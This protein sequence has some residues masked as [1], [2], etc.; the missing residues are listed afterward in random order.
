MNSNKL[1]VSLAL[2]NT[3]ACLETLHTLAPLISLAEIRLDAM[4]SFDLPRLIASAPCP[5]ILTCR[6]PREGGAFSGPESERLALLTRAMDLGCAYV[7][8]EWDSL[9]FLTRPAAS[10]T[11]IIVSRH[12]YEQMPAHLW[13]T[14]DTLRSQADVVK[15]VGLAH[16][17]ADMLPVFDLLHRA[18]SPVIALAMGEAGQLTRLLAPCF[19]SC[20]LTYAAPT[21]ANATA[22]GQLS[23]YDMV[24]IYHIHQGGPQTA[25]HL[26]L[27][28]AAAQAPAIIQQNT[29]SVPGE[30]IHLPLVIS[31]AEAAKLI[32]ALRSA[33]PRLT[34][35][36]DPVLAERIGE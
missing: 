7:D 2:T 26:H 34:I 36:A 6:P 8:I 24:Q 28:A 18:T 3:D 19:P 27:C 10:P 11:K 15:L 31:A 16:R 22:A 35:T 5:L 32:P 23:I 4:T 29:A 13:P 20:F 33:L 25:I 1:A 12:W 9:E 21:A 30:I 14:Y 17:P